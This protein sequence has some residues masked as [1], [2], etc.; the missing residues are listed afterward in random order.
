MDNDDFDGEDLESQRQGWVWR[1][2]EANLNPDPNPTAYRRPR[3]NSPPG[4]R[5]SR[6]RRLC[7]PATWNTT[8]AWGHDG[9]GESNHVRR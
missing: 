5:T 6:T 4:K 1:I 7:Q 3:S 8:A 2:F 9:V